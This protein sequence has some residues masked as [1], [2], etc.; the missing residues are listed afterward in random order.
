VLAERCSDASE[1]GV[2]VKVRKIIDELIVSGLRL[3]G[4]ALGDGG[5]LG[6]FHRSISDGEGLGGFHR[7]ISDGEGLS[8]VDQRIGGL[9]CL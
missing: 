8:C 3:C 2:D 7:S 5:G 6:G 4:S 9:G 1:R